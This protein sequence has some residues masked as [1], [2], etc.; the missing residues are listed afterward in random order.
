MQHAKDLK[1]QPVNAR[2]K[3]HKELNAL[4]ITPVPL[5]IEDVSALVIGWQLAAAD[6]TEAIGNREL[7]E[8]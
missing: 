1:R 3:H 4:C 6:A 8:S 7:E 5:T 2:G